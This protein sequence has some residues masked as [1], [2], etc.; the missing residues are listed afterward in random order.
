M[1][2]FLFLSILFT[3]LIFRCILCIHDVNS[4][5]CYQRSYYIKNLNLVCDVRDLHEKPESEDSK[6][7]AS[8]KKKE[9]KNLPRIDP[10]KVCI[11][12]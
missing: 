9:A 4:M 11:S 7:T 3:A 5:I 1:P 8:Q 10:I 12:I 6:R 2:E